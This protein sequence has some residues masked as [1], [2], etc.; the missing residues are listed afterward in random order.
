MGAAGRVCKM[1][2]STKIVIKRQKPRNESVALTRIH[3]SRKIGGAMSPLLSPL[4][5]T[6]TPLPQDSG[7]WSQ[8]P[9]G[10]LWRLRR[11][12]EVTKP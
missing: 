4:L 9:H 2:A 12:V 8:T 11:G 7:V 6:H 5:T 3:N 10:P 1:G